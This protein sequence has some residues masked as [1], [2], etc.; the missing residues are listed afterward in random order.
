MVQAPTSVEQ[1]S[2]AQPG[3]SAN[4]ESRDSLAKSSLNRINKTRPFAFIFFTAVFLT[5]FW[6]WS[7]RGNLNLSAESG[8]G[9]WLGVVGGSMMLALLLYP[10]RKHLRF[11][12]RWGKVSLWFSTHMMMGVIGPLL[13]LFHSDFSLGSTNSNL[14]L[15]C[16][17][18]VALSGFL[19]RFF[20]SRV[21]Y[22]LYGGKA[23][24][25]ELRRELK[26]SK[27][28]LGDEVTL[29]ISILA[30][31]RNMEKRIFKKRNFFI[32]FFLMPFFSVDVML[33]R[34][35]AR[36]QLLGDLRKQAKKNKWG[37][38]IYKVHSR[39]A[40][41]DMQEYFYL[42]KKTY[43]FSIYERLLS[44]WHMFHLPLFIMLLLT[45]V[46][47]VVVVHLY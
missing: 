45:G 18:V 28:H 5:G 36:R 12:R 10:A 11:M 20:Y 43:G 34:Y 27:G 32:T 25:K 1:V 46:I 9:Y 4:E 22:G 44:M 41:S 40:L 37:R 42:L 26:L 31:L 47:H 39:K 6:G 33:A 3:D 21:H 30:R 24:L 14:A 13:I 17:T 35:K 19:G 23:N 2:A 8:I 38:K 29:S 15:F 16:M 7:Q